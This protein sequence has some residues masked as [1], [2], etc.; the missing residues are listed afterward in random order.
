MLPV[1]ALMRCEWNAKSR[2]KLKEC[3]G[4]IL[5]EY[6][7]YQE[8]WINNNMITKWYSCQKNKQNSDW[9]ELFTFVFIR[10]N[11]LNC[12]NIFLSLFT[13]HHLQS[14][15]KHGSREVSCEQ[16]RRR[17]YFSTLEIIAQK[18]TKKCIFNWGLSL[19]GPNSETSFDQS[20]GPL[21]IWTDD[22]HS[23]ELKGR[24]PEEEE[25]AKGNGKWTIGESTDE[26][27]AQR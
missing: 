8:M 3:E 13:I 11:S 21:T 20:L 25:M 10:E 12:S 5:K 24:Q 14:I 23:I 9:N 2:S 7:L 18:S 4:I 26:H 15:D 1:W 27:S 16:W 17:E 22:G 19:N 6:K